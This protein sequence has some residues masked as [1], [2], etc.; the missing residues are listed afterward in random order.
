MAEMKQIQSQQEE[1]FQEVL[2]LIPACRYLAAKIV[3]D[4]LKD[5]L[6]VSPNQSLLEE[7]TDNKAIPAMLTRER[8]ARA[9][10][11]I[12]DALD[13]SWILGN[14]LFGTTTHYKLADD[15]TLMLRLEGESS[16]LPLFEQLAVIREVDLFTEWL[17]FCSA[18][19]TVDN[20]GAAEMVVFFQ[21]FVPP[22]SRDALIHAYGVDCLQES[23]RILLLG[24]SVDDW[25]PGHTAQPSSSSS[26]SSSARASTTTAPSSAVPSDTSTNS[27]STSAFGRFFGESGKSSDKSSAT[28]ST[29]SSGSTTSST[30]A[31]PWR[32][33]AG[34][35]TDRMEV[36][37]FWS[38]VQVTSPTTA[39]IT[40]VTRIDP[41]VALPQTLL[42]FVI[43]NVA[44]ILLV[45]FQRQA[46][47]VASNPQC[48]HAMKIRQD[49]A[50]YESWLLPKIRHY[51]DSRGWARPDVSSLADE[52]T[53]SE[54][55]LVGV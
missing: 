34:W 10:L 2:S 35:L 23:G 26:S 45:L 22:I 1:M 42:N 36:K 40:M 19:Q 18:S 47:S 11:A 38:I 20:L 31:T 32:K 27:R 21:L 54:A 15:G 12:G 13:S 24:N 41:K 29:S 37:S 28:A 16:D 3:Y 9:L 14:T 51:C 7:M 4:R 6:S 55:L 39:K 48:K 33:A 17:P 53:G 44:G 50:F 25:T 46:A 8:D 30:A 5:S 49:R 43:K 52:H